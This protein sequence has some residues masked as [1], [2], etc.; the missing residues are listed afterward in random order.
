MI[1]GATEQSAQ[2]SPLPLSEMRIIGEA[3]SHWAALKR[4]YNLFLFHQPPGEP[5][6]P[7]SRPNLDLSEAQQAQVTGQS[8]G[9]DSG[10]YV[11]F[12][13]IE[14]PPLSWDFSLRSASDKLIGS[15]NR[16]FAGFA[17]EI[18]T[19]TGVYALRMDAAGLEEEAG[20]RHII[21]KTAQHERDY[22]DVVGGETTEMGMTLDQ[23]AVMLATA[24]TVDY[25]Y[26]SRH[27]HGGGMGMMPLWIGG[28]EA[29][30]GG[31]AA[32][33]AV[34][35]AG[36]GEASGAVVGGAGRA[37]GGVASGAGEGAMAGAGTMAGYEAMQRGTGGG[38]YGEQQSQPQQPMDDAS[39]QAP[40]YQPPPQQGEDIWGQQGGNS[41]GW[42]AA[43]GGDGAG[44]G[45]D[46]WGQGGQD[47]W[48]GQ[49]GD[50]G[51]GGGGGG[52]GEGGGGGSG[53]SIWD[54][55]GE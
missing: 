27:S 35:A 1:P 46:V 40:E 21:S 24:V 26:F 32:G 12:A 23:R 8:A 13:Y 22:K 29:A 3:Q 52:G 31:A 34:G 45:E 4:K 50:V 37:V 15:V 42:G 10:Q 39:P 2:I 30:E 28:G 17:R 51:G 33:G 54:I 55:F 14:E 7:S 6:I 38:G 43:G 20:K 53:W 47:P 49:G 16:N 48:S 9:A 44:K 36:A 25:D 5:D 11:Q 41:D 18:F 19:D